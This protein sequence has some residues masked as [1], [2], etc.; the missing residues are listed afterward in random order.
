MT[1]YS[2]GMPD[3]TPKHAVL[4]KRSQKRLLSKFDRPIRPLTNRLL[5]AYNTKGY[6][7]MAYSI[8]GGHKR[9]PQQRIKIMVFVT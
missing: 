1:A 6:K 5:I 4:S 7:S 9:M 3:F 8:I 2:L